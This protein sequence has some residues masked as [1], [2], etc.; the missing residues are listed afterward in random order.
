MPYL[1][2]VAVID[3]DVYSN[4]I[5]RPPAKITCLEN[6]SPR[7][8]DFP[9]APPLRLSRHLRLS[10]PSFSRGLRASV[11][12][13]PLV[14]FVCEQIQRM[15]TKDIGRVGLP[16]RLCN[17]LLFYRDGMEINQN[18][19][20]NFSVHP[21]STDEASRFSRFVVDDNVHFALMIQSIRY[22]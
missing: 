2:S 5:S 11:N 19:N 7:Y 15:D 6:V 13:L 12:K 22:L 21:T 16:A 8:I 14:H 4:V 1:R 17:R 20:H 10:T 3:S 9:F 18:T